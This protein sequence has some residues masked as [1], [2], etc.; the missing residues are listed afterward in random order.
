[1]SNNFLDYNHPLQ[2]IDSYVPGGKKYQTS[3]RNF[4]FPFM[5]ESEPKRADSI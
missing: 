4:I 5:D 1:M 3:R 2:T